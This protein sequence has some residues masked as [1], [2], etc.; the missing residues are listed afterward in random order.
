[1]ILLDTDVCIELLRGNKKVIENRKKTDDLIAV[2]FMTVGEL[3]YGAE[4][5]GNRDKNIGLIE[6]FLLTVKIIHSNIAVL[7]KFGELKNDLKKSDNLITDADLLIASTA[8]IK[9]DRLI[10]GNVRHFSRFE[11]LKV[12]NWIH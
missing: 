5:S 9:C 2:S 12:E 1:M 7:R 4:K 10:T 6:E 3:Y 8:V 11:G